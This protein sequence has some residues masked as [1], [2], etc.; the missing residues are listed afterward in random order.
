M[1]KPLY[2]IVRFAEADEKSRSIWDA[3]IKVSIN[4]TFLQSRRFLNY[5]P[6]DRF[7]DHSVVFYNDKNCLVAVCPACETEDNGKK[8][9]YS[10][11]GST[12]GGLI[13]SEEIY[14][15]KHIIPLIQNLEKYLISC[16]FNEIYLK[17]TPDIFSIERTSL[18]EYALYYNGYIEYKELNPFIEYSS[19][20]DNIISNFSQGKRSHV[21]KCI[22]EHM[23][24]HVINSDEDVGIYYD[25][26]CE[27]LSKYNL[28]PVHTINEL[29][30]FKN[31]RLKN[32]CQFLG[33][34]LKN[35]MVAGG[36]VFFFE[37]T[38]TAHTQYLSAK[39]DYLKLSPVTFLY[40]YL[41]DEMRKRGYQRLSW[42]ICTEDFG[43][44]LNEGL[45]SSKEDYGSTYSNNLTYYKKLGGGCLT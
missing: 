38:K 43:R 12:Y 8:I 37:K 10:H 34:Y 25:I 18:L 3:F 17:I 24:T 2:S 4:G 32:E 30:D 16:G 40:Y 36:M 41:I 35:E 23:E 13:L 45:I 27:N 28:K 33:T 42:G 6:K 11:K 39:A 9:F 21:N 44:Y 14:K 29:L 26:L 20:K 22:R 31:S 5:H 15:A 1:S 19:Y 7:R